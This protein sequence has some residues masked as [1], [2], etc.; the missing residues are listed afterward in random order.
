MI[1]KTFDNAGKITLTTKWQGQEHQRNLRGKSLFWTQTSVLWNDTVFSL[2]H[3]QNDISLDN[4]V[5]ILGENAALHKS[6]LA[7]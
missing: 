4:Q 1:T 7:F 2:N 6:A 3:S 5:A